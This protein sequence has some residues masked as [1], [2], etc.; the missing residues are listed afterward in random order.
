VPDTIVVSRA[1]DGL[2]LD[3]NPG[4][5]RATGWTRA[6]AV[7]QSTLGLDLW[8][9]QEARA[10]MVAELRATGEVLDREFTFRRR[11]RTPRDGLF[12]A[13]TF[14]MQGELCVV[15]IMRDVTERLEAE[16]LARLQERR[17]AQAVEG[18][19]LGTW[20]WDP[21][22]GQGHVNARWCEMLGYAPDEL[23]NPTATWRQR[24]HPE[25]A[26]RVAEAEGAYFEGRSGRY[27]VEHRVRHRDGH[28]VWILSTGSIVARDAEGRASRVCG[29]HL[30]VTERHRLRE[31]HDRLEAQ[32]RQAQKL[33]AVG[34]VA[35]GVAHDFN[36]LLTVQLGG[37]AVL[38]ELPGLPAEAREVIDEV[39][40]SARSAAALTR[41]LLA[42]SRRQVLR[43]ER[44]EL[45]G[46][47]SG[48]LGMLRRV[49]REDVLLEVPPAPAPLWLD[50][51]VGMTQQVLM[52]LAVN[53]RDAMPEGGRLTLHCDQVE[54]PAPVTG[55]GGEAP[56]GRYVRLSVADTGH[57]M[58]QA[59]QRRIFEPFFTTK[60]TGH[61]TGLGLATVYGIVKQHG[62]WIRV[63][64]QAGLGTTI[65]V[66]W[67]AADG[68]PRVAP[69]P[70]EA[71][72]AVVEVPA[73]RGERLLLVEDDAAVR[74]TV[75]GWLERTGYLVLPCG[76]GPDALAR[77]RAE[78]GRVDVVLTDMMLPGGMSGRQV[79]ERLRELAPG[80]PAVMMSGYSAELVAQGLPAGVELVEKPYQPQALA[81]ALRSA[82]DRAEG[83]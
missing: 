54:V 26:P 40:Q 60:P 76:D 44:V 72:P 82:L 56:P 62:G 55:Q 66:H 69:A 49:L 34:Q 22:T 28:W 33:E 42:F 23:E 59:T 83:R 15:F 80:L 65:R 64:S 37:L 32:L 9:D 41:Q 48:F 16:A 14:Q 57:G 79:L 30:D 27:E 63:E 67:P 68:G 8:V 58:D 46:L 36:N 77:W 81:R 47:V 35:G 43:V 51:D 5:E 21:R 2:L 75:T 39:E 61:G 74:R 12:S 50:A 3:V 53:A 4:F 71:G 78:G 45:G 25:D 24:L 13:R 18:S 17:L 70:A 38:K 10:R 31:E 6:E 20:D 7:G 73:G 19:K 1:R 52:N 11:D 29:T